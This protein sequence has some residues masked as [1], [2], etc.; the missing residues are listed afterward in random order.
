MLNEYK[1]VKK[2]FRRPQTHFYFGF[3]Q[4]PSWTIKLGKWLF[5]NMDKEKTIK[6]RLLKFIDKVFGTTSNPCLPVWRRGNSIRL[7]S[8]H[9]TYSLD[10]NNYGFVWNPDFKEKLNKW[11]LSWLKPSYE[12]PLWLSC[13]FFKLDMVWKWKYDDVRYEFPPQITIMLFNISF[14]IWWNKPKNSGGYHDLYWESIL[15][16][17]Y[18]YLDTIKDKSV[19]MMT[20]LIEL[21]DYCGCWTS[22]GGNNNEINYTWELQP[23]YLRNKEYARI[24]K[25]HQDMKESEMRQKAEDLKCLKCGA[26]VKLEEGIVLTSLPPKYK[27]TCPKCGEVKYLDKEYKNLW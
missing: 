19:D 20:Q 1:K 18:K 23:S 15:N 21:S 14:S 25:E 12:L 24:L 6:Y 7:L 11:H 3:W 9:Q 5:S 17:N 26:K 22:I 16:Y 2:I 10:Q 4:H 13:Y 8:K 27:Y